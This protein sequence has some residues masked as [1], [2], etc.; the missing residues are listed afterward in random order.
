L[1]RTQLPRFGDRPVRFG[2]VGR[3][4]RFKGLHVLLDALEGLRDGARCSLQV[5]GAARSP[6]DEQYRAAALA[7][8]RGTAGILD[9][10]SVQ[11]GRLS[12]AFASIDVLVVPS[13]LPEAFGLV[14][15]EAFSA[16]R[17]VIVSDA[18]ALPELVRDGVDGWVVRGDDVAA[19]RARLQACV[20]EPARIETAAAAVPRPRTM[21]QHVDDLLAAYGRVISDT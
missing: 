5:L 7:R 15:L 17:P 2:Y 21:Q 9:H 20:D 1:E 14:V 16:G 11:P 18:G 19:L 10:G 8:Y 3:I 6:W 13:V 4:E 12:N